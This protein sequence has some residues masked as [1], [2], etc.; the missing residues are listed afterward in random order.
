MRKLAAGPVLL[1][2][3]ACSST[4][5][6][7]ARRPA[8][9]DV[10][11]TVGSTSITLGEVDDKALQQSASGFGNVKLSQALFDARRVALD[12]LIANTLMDDAAKA[13]S[14]DRSA[15]IEKEITSKLPMVTDAD[16]AT[17]YQANQARVQGASL[18]QVRQPIRT[19]LTQEHMQRVRDA[20]LLTLKARSSV[21]VMLDPPRVAV[22]NPSTSPARGPASAPVEVVEFSDFQ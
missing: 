21:K 14:I 18:D 13:Q 4:S 19:F 9:T 7:S 22:K 12:E 6:Q 5:A 16:V 10:V 15:L 20:Y 2:L 8:Q 1:L 11:A 17:W 3:T